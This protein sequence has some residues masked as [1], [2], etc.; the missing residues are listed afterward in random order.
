MPKRKE[1]YFISSSVGFIYRFG[2]EFGVAWETW[3]SGHKVTVLGEFVK[4]P[5]NGRPKLMNLPDV[6]SNEIC[7]SIIQREIELIGKSY[8]N[9]YKRE[10]KKEVMPKFEILE[11][12]YKPFPRDLRNELSKPEELN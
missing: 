3:S 2:R 6:V 10:G 7:L 12:P 4:D 11:V 8:H 9:Y 1:P 5:E